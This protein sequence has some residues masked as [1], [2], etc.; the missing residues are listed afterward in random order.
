MW[1]LYKHYTFLFILHMKSCLKKKINYS[2]HLDNLQRE[3][4]ENE[5]TVNNQTVNNQTV[6][7][8]YIKK[9]IFF[10]HNLCEIYYVNYTY[11][12]CDDIWYDDDDYDFFLS[13]ADSEIMNC[14]HSY[15]LYSSREIKTFLWQPIFNRIPTYLAS[16]FYNQNGKHDEK[17]D[18]DQEQEQEQEQEQDEEHDIDTSSNSLFSTRFF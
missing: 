12:Q 2:F 11:Y 4:N 18:E 5:L 3:L 10:S 14:F 16:F 1:L 9:Q 7:T 15:P 8:D 17:H 6:T 13:D